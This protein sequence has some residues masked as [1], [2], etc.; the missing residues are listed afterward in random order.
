MK[1]VLVVALAVMM[2]VSAN[3]QHKVGSISIIPKGFGR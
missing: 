2:A 3:A 1:K